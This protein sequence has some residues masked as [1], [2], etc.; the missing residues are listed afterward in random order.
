MKLQDQVVSFD[1]AKQLKEAGYPQEGWFYH[2]WDNFGNKV[3]RGISSAKPCNIQNGWGYCIAPTVA[4]LGEALPHLCDSNKHCDNKG[5]SC[6]HVTRGD[7]TVEAK[8]EADARAL[9]YLKL[10]QEGLL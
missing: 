4:E 10:K 7:L 2:T 5:W 6:F 3:Y 9:M 8:T 1:V